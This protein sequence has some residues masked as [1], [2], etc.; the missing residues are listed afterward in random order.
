MLN[1]AEPAEMCAYFIPIPSFLRGFLI[2]FAVIVALI[3]FGIPIHLFG[4]TGTFEKIGNNPSVFSMMAAMFAPL[5]FWLF[6]LA[7]P[8]KNWLARLELE[9]D[10][11]RFIPKP[12]LRWIGEPSEEV[13]FSSLPKEI[14]ICRGSKD[15]SPYGFRVLL[16][17]A[18][19]RDREIKVE[20][21]E[22]LSTHQSALLIE[23]IA[24]ATGLS[25]KLVQRQHLE[26]DAVQEVPWI[27][28][29]RSLGLG[30]IAKLAFASLPFVGGSVVAYLNAG[31]VVIAVVG[32]AIW[33]SQTLAVLILDRASD[34]R[35]KSAMLCWLTTLFT[36]GATYA[37]TVC[38]VSFLLRAN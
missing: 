27:P 6:L 26:D 36:F 9:R 19:D 37:A 12:I 35:S 15:K 32:I 25:P 28:A 8:P 14:S 23:R 2:A 24:S 16:R 30:A 4:L 22:R 34:R 21:G 7:F 38:L 18:N 33:F 20:T 5:F 17:W 11:F 29:G 13:V 31:P 10:C 3:F 1:S